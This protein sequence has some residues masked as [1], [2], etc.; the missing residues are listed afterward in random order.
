M[1]TFEVAGLN[2]TYAA[3]TLITDSAA[4]GTA[5]ASGIITTTRLTRAAFAAHNI[6]RNNEN[7]TAEDYLKSEVAFLPVAVSATSSPG[8]A[9]ISRWTSRP[10]WLR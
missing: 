7:E 4:A 6:S 8:P 1:N 9:W 5:L 2:T 3:D 10:P